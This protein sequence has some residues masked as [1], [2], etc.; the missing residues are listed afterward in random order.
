M[1]ARPG[2]SAPGRLS[3]RTMFRPSRRAVPPTTIMVLAQAGQAR[4]RRMPRRS[5]SRGLSRSTSPGALQ[6]ACGGCASP[7][8]GARADIAGSG[9]SAQRCEPPFVALR[10]SSHQIRGR[11]CRACAR[12]PGLLPHSYCVARRP[13]C[14]SRTSTHIGARASAPAGDRSDARSPN[15]HPYR[16]GFWAKVILKNAQ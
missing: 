13:R 3:S 15:R 5:S 12:A 11:D 16:T 7:S 6:R 1:T 9:F 14:T 10:G 4:Y 2:A 8:A